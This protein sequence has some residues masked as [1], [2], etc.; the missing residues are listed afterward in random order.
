MLFTSYLTNAKITPKN[1]GDQMSSALYNSCK[2]LLRIL[3]SL[4]QVRT[5]I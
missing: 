1:Q 2:M 3:K 5:E 4:N